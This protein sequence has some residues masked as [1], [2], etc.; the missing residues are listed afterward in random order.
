M[1]M[2]M[3]DMFHLKTRVY[4][5]KG[6]DGEKLIGSYVYTYDLNFIYLECAVF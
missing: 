4:V 2:M 1:T 5:I 3:I 6:Y